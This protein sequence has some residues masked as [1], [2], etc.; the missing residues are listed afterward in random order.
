MGAAGS[1]LGVVT[2]YA[3]NVGL[4]FIKDKLPGLTDN[5][6]VNSLKNVYSTMQ[7]KMPALTNVLTKTAKDVGGSLSLS[8]LSKLKNPSEFAKELGNRALGSLA[9]NAKAGAMDFIN[10]D[11]NNITGGAVSKVTDAVDNYVGGIKNEIGSSLGGISGQ[12]K[13]IGNSIV[14]GVKDT[15]GS[16][17]LDIGKEIS[18]SIPGGLGNIKFVAGAVGKIMDINIPKDITGSFKNLAIGTSQTAFKNFCGSSFSGAV[19]SAVSGASGTGQAVLQKASGSISS[20][21]SHIRL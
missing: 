12:F 20:I 15:F 3:K 2:D 5:Q 4:D 18:N 13:T 6:I 11:L 14:T 1:A 19:C 8:D 7:D 10:N 9:D 16:G 21:T 17:V